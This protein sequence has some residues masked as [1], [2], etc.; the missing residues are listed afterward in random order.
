MN[1]L[2][3]SEWYKLPKVTFITS[4]IL[5]VMISEVLAIG[6][7]YYNSHFSS[8]EASSLSFLIYA[9]AWFIPV[10]YFLYGVFSA[11]IIST[12]YESNMWS[13]LLVSK[14]SKR[15]I[16]FAKFLVLLGLMFITM[17]VFMV[18]HLLTSL[19]V[20]GHIPNLMAF[21]YIMFAVFIGTLGMQAIQ[22]FIALV[23]ENKVYVIA[24]GILLALVSL[25]MQS[26][27]MPFKIPEQIINAT[28]ILD[29]NMLVFFDM[30]FFV[31]GIY[32]TFVFV[33]IMVISNFYINRKEF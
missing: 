33:I 6:L 22:F 3:K 30:S 13:V 18:C 4:I 7:Y 17:I 16:I 24:V 29:H 1:S 15:E 21:V 27:M 2:I 25:L 19:F 23:I 5:A 11:K 12:E 28:N 20:N 8:V 9:L 10:F 32:S 14:K 31:F 26:E